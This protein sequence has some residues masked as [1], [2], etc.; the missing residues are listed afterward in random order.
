MNWYKIAAKPKEEKLWG[1]LLNNGDYYYLKVDNRIITPFIQM[2]DND[3][4]VSPKEVMEKKKML[5]HISLL[6]K[7]MKAKN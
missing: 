5:E 7:M 3:K 2:L 6:L 4:V 1:T